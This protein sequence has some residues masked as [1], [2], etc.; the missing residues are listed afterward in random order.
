[1]SE[2]IGETEDSLV[3]RIV[4]GGGGDISLDAVEG[5]EGAYNLNHKIGERL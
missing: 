1:M 4:R 5:F 2:A 3:L